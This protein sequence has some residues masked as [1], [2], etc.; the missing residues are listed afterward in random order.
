M[1]LEELQ[2]MNYGF[3]QAKAIDPRHWDRDVLDAQ[4]S[5]QGE[6]DVLH[7]PAGLL[8]KPKICPLPVLIGVQC[9]QS[10]CPRSVLAQMIQHPLHGRI[11]R[12]V[13]HSYCGSN[14]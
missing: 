10:S 6:A 13:A 7:G 5:E 12:S 8:N 14:C 4:T 9:C 2:T 11:R 3:I 1:T